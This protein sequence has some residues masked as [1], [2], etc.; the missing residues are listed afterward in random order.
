MKSGTTWL[1]ALMLSALNRHRY[2][3]PD[4]YHHKHNPHS[5]FSALDIESYPITDFTNASTPRLLS[6]CF[7][8]TLLPACMSSCKFVYVCRDQ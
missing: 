5:T 1:K 7:A 4:H 3:F 2:T 6:T 8:H